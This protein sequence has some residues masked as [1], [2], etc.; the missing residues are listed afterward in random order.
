VRELELWTGRLLVMTSPQSAS[1]PAQSEDHQ[2]P[3]RITFFGY[4]IG[5]ELRAFT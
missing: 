4:L 5:L 3:H 1:S 2:E